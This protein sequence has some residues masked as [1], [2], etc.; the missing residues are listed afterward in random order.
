MMSSDTAPSNHASFPD[1]DLGKLCMAFLVVEIHTLPLNDVGS[2]LI[3]RII[4]GIDSVAVPFFFVTSSFFCFRNLVPSDFKDRF[5]SAAVRARKTIRKQLTLYV[6]WTILLLPLALFGAHLR[7]WSVSETALRIIRGVVFVGE[8]DFTWPLWYLLASV[9][10]F[11]L[12]YIL[13]RGGVS[14]RAIM[15]ASS[16]LLLFGY[17]I[18]V[19]LAWDDAPPVIAFM[20]DLYNVVF[21]TARNGLFEGFF[22]VAIGMCIGFGWNKFRSW[23]PAWTVGGIVLGLAGCI[24]V[25]PSAHLPFC[26]LSAVSLFLLCTRRVSNRAH[27]WARKASTVVYLVHM[28]FVV[29]FVYGICGHT[30]I[31]FYD[32]SISHMALYAFTLGCSLLTAAIVIPLGR[33]FPIVK[34]V[35]GV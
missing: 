25:S 14:P 17:A 16:A 27:S 28:V 23:P 19:C 7:A 31:S 21:S 8:N 35:F 10:A 2:D 33:R 12:V 30:E 22:Y 26:A 32:A 1:L 9:V 11:S 3:A 15:L 6:A 34:T 20:A 18:E 5:S 4:A 24:L 29:I 13:L